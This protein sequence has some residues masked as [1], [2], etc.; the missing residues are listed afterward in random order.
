M[1]LF[2]A[3]LLLFV[4]KVKTELKA[5]PASLQLFVDSAEPEHLRRALTHELHEGE[6]SQVIVQKSLPTGD[7][8]FVC[9]N[10][11]VYV[12]ERK[13][14]SDYNGCLDD[15]RYRDQLFRLCQLPI[16]RDHVT[17]LLENENEGKIQ[18][19][20]GKS[21]ILFEL[22]KLKIQYGIDVDWTMSGMETLFYIFGTLRLM[23]RHWERI[24]EDVHEFFQIDPTNDITLPLVTD[25]LNKKREKK[26]KKEKKEEKETSEQETPQES[27]SQTEK[28]VSVP[29]NTVK[30]RV[31]KKV[32]PS[33][34]EDYCNFTKLAKRGNDTPENLFRNQIGSILGMGKSKAL[35]VVERFPSYK[36]LV[37]FL[38]AQ[39]AKQMLQTVASLQCKGR[40]R[41]QNLGPAL[42]KKLVGSLLTLSSERV[43]LDQGKTSS[44][45]KRKAPESTSKSKSKSKTKPSTKNK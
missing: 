40:K 15:P 21:R 6:L 7:Y 38:D 28:D 4:A 3:K 2:E 10:L 42:A 11:L 43:Q 37:N 14:L 1:D 33:I 27:I 45:N 12:L 31:I 25:L 8:W 35:A 23:C 16:P 13:S 22:R 20:K 9:N 44:K 29:E 30:G 19:Y 24:V 26:E 5:C 41:T 39:G 36:S 17:Y 32:R 34:L 18:H